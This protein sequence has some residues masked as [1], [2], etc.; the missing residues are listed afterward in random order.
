MIKG[1]VQ[2]RVLMAGIGMLVKS[3]L[4]KVLLLVDVVAAQGSD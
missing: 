1:F 3:Y 2:L 4:V